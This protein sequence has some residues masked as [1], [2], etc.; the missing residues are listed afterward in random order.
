MEDP[1]SN[2]TGPAQLVAALTSVRRT[3]SHGLIAPPTHELI[4]FRVRPVHESSHADDPGGSYVPGEWTEPANAAGGIR[5]VRRKERW[6]A[7]LLLVRHGESI[8]NLAHN[9]PLGGS[10]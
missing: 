5:M 9:G 10:E 4:A 7:S 3:S 1:S 8:G 6:P 2:G